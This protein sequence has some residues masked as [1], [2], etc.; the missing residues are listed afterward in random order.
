MS[1]NS[2]KA[3]STIG[4]LRGGP[5]AAHCQPNVTANQVAHQLLFNG[6]NGS[7]VQTKIKVNRKKYNS[8][9]GFKRPLTLE[10]LEA[11][12]STLT[13]GKAIGLDNIATEQIKNF[14]PVARKWLLAPYNNCL[15]TRKLPNIWK[16]AHVTA[17][18]KPGKDPSLPKNYRPISLLSHIYKL[19]ERLILTRVNPVVD[20]HLIP[21]QAGFRPGKSTTSQVLNL[22]QYIENGF[23][24]G[25][26]T[27][28]VF[29]DLPAAYDTANH[30]CLLRKILEITKDIH[31]TELIESMLE[32][33]LFFVELG[34]KKS[35]WRRLK[36]G[37]PQ[38]S[39]LA[40]LLFN[41]YTNDRPTK[42]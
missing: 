37:L 36:N 20:E 28:V 27:G 14:G 2:K 26:V 19:F 3:W 34:N 15:K 40:T 22:T 11:G 4:K 21:E 8:D 39:V 41:I 10:E 25:M 30:R 16:K 5:K 35:R 31:L 24:K 1:R 32:N 17:L 38:G 18:L 13:P 12:I 7:K 6:K 23:E 9:P 42:N 33:R 29:V